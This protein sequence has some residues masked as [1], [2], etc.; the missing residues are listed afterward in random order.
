MNRD[1]RWLAALDV[2]T[3]GRFGAVVAAGVVIYESEKSIINEMFVRMPDTAIT[4][5]A[6]RAALVQALA[7]EKPTHT[8]YRPMLETFGVWLVENLRNTLWLYSGDYQAVATLFS[9]LC[10]QGFIRPEICPELHGVTAMVRTV[11]NSSSA[12][13]EDYF[14]K[15]KLP[16]LTGISEELHPIRVCVVSA[17]VY[18][19]IV[20]GGGG[21]DRVV[22]VDLPKWQTLD[23]DDTLQP[24][25]VALPIGASEPTQGFNEGRAAAPFESFQPTSASSIEQ[26][27]ITGD[28]DDD[29]DDK[30][31]GVPIKRPVKRGRAK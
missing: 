9:D 8:A 7:N 27:E 12:T 13:I 20:G 10:K 22:D 5:P 31:K 4:D 14:D 16:L 3:N 26:T 25:P 1:Y 23:A 11:A 24:A 18:F 6:E 30:K 21:T 28:S 15:K 29:I 17:A 2:K 19:H